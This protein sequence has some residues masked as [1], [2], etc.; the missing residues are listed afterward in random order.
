MLKRLLLGFTAAA[1]FGGCAFAGIKTIGNGAAY[2]DDSPA[3]IDCT[4]APVGFCKAVLGSPTGPLGDNMAQAGA[5]PGSTMLVPA[6]GPAIGGGGQIGAPT[7]VVPPAP[8]SGGIIDVGQLLGPTIQTIVSDVLDALI[9][10]ALSYI[11]LK[12]KT[13]FNIDIDEG[14]RTAI[15][16]AV[17][18]QA[19]SLV[20]DG[21]VKLDQN[22]KISVDNKALA[23]SVNEVLAVVPDAARHFNITGDQIA[24]RI[25]D[26]MPQVVSDIKML[27]KPK[28]PAKAA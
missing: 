20:A 24:Q 8:A 5:P 1:L 26:A 14:H 12:L 3:I 10:S 21:M 11:F 9:L 2:I 15:I 28:D 4:T 23:D 7:Y 25:I 13:K 17:Q 27:D 6:P 22:A 19:G 16:N 18:R